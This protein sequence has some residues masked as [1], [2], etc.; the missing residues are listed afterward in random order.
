MFW[1]GLSI[2]NAPFHGLAYD[3]IKRRIQIGAM[4]PGEQFPAERRLSETLGI[5]RAT[6]REALKRL[7]AEGYIVALRGAKGGNF[8]ADEEAINAL[9]RAT[10]LTRPDL[11]WRSL[12]YLGAILEHAGALACERR[13]PTDLA[14]MRKAVD[15]LEAARSAGDLREAQFLFLAAV[16]RASANA[17][18]GEAIETALAG[19]ASPFKPASVPERAAELLEVWKALAESITNRSRM[20]AAEATRNLFGQMSETT[21]AAMIPDNPVPPAFPQVREAAIAATEP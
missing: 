20:R 18:F 17:F 16:G 12:E 1:T 15:L 5:A 9:A 10:L 11:V 6:L 7:E 2:R 21:L 3:L 14:D 8:V 4:R 19:L 13:T